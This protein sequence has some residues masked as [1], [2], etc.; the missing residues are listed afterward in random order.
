[1]DGKRLKGWFT[2]L[3]MG[4]GQSREGHG[5]AMVAVMGRY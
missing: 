1:M 4:M 5:D 3:G 2:G